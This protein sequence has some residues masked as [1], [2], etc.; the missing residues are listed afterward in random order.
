MYHAVRA[1]R[2]PLAP[3][4]RGVTHQNSPGVVVAPG[5]ASAA[6]PAPA[7]VPAPTVADQVDRPPPPQ[8]S[9]VVS[10]QTEPQPSAAQRSDPPHIPPAG[11]GMQT[12]SRTNAINA[13]QRLQPLATPALPATVINHSARA[14]APCPLAGSRGLPPPGGLA[15]STTPAASPGNPPVPLLATSSLPASLRDHMLDHDPLSLGPMPP[16]PALSTGRLLTSTTYPIRSTSVGSVSAQPPLSACR[17]ITF[18]DRQSTL[19]CNH[20]GSPHDMGNLSVLHS[21]HFASRESS[22]RVELGVVVWNRE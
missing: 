7:P 15:G 4:P 20:G 13:A 21:D 2:R 17:S 3:Q 8:P 22:S 5:P 19:D 10:R 9:R 1:A 6:P 11:S 14:L 12:R 16:S 18:S